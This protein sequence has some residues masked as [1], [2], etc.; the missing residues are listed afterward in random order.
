[1]LKGLCGQACVCRTTRHFRGS[2][3][4]DIE[5]PQPLASQLRESSS[6]SEGAHMSHDGDLDVRVAGLEREA[7]TWRAA[8][9]LSV[10]LAAAAWLVPSVSAQP[11]R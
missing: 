6:S 7:R 10:L 1:M 3:A 9:A 5:A 4:I 8:A 11:K 2:V